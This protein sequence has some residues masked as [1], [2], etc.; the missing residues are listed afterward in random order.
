MDKNLGAIV[1]T[2]PTDE[3]KYPKLSSFFDKVIQGVLLGTVFLVPILVLPW[4]TDKIELQKQTILVLLMSVGIV[5]WIGKAMAERKVT[6]TRSWLHLV[7]VGFVIGYAVV[8]W[9]SVDRFLSFAGHVGQYQW[10]VVTLFGFI[11]L[12]FLMT[13]TVREEESWTKMLFVFLLSSGVVAFLSLLQLFGL[14]I[15]SWLGDIKNAI[16][17]NTIG[18]I[19][20]LAVF[21][22]IALLIST[23]LLASNRSSS[24]I[25]PFGRVG[26][27]FVSI[28][29]ALTLAVA[30]IVDFW[31]VWAMLLFGSFLLVLLSSLRFRHKGQLRR[32]L[33]PAGLFV[34]SLLFLFIKTPI[35]LEIGSE[36]SPSFNATWSIARDALQERP[37]TGSGPGTWMHDYAK[38]RSVAVNMSPYW[39]VRFERGVS[40]FFTF[41]A[42]IGLIGTS[43]WLIL[44]IS[45][46]SK[47]II[48]LV[49]ESSDKR[50]LMYQVS[51][52]GW[53]TSV[54]AFFIYNYNVTHQFAFWFLFAMIASL[55]ARSQLTWDTRKSVVHSS[56]LSITFL[57]LT[58]GVVSGVWLLSQR[59][60]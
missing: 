19:N 37:L 47:S 18:N 45:G 35:H 3:K 24:P 54:F 26:V 59:Y 28:V 52:V 7:A 42:S 29:L 60:V 31:V 43:L 11:L 58:A 30:V 32:L 25:I 16:T 38:F 27:V 41:V 50:W 2:D 57:L 15:F 14:P 36:V 6:I 13:Q 39:T 55:V 22:A 53:A 10:A 49:T 48:H 34:L 56:I 9:F 5:A 21:L 44:V 20:S 12:Y 4:A 46:L 33:F 8:S 40:G 23:S 51:S 1:Q 17:F